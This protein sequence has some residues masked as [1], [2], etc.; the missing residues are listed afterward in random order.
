M[1]SQAKNILSEGQSVIMDA[2]F[3]KVEERLKAK[4][5][6]EEMG[7]DFIIIECTLDEESI[8]KRLA[9]RR[10][11]ETTSDGR[12]EIY[13]PQKRAFAPVV[14]ASPQKH[15]IIDTSEPTDN[16]VKKVKAIISP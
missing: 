16:L 5:L 13:E 9:Q 6:A 14:E 15:V 4:G 11:Q 1:F 3:I 10:E 7:A 8:K 2:S 12:W